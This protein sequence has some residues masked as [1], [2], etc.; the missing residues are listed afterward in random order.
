MEGTGHEVR[1]IKKRGEM[2]VHSLR[3]ARNK[4]ERGK[5]KG[6]RFLEQLWGGVEN[7]LYS[8]GTIGEDIPA[9]A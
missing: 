9:S 2:E 8:P 7:G 3:R 4:S 5:K 6:E 1:K